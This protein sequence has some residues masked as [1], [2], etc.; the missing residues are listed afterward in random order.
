MKLLSL[1]YTEAGSVEPE[2]KTSPTSIEVTWVELPVSS[3]GIITLYEIQYGPT[4]AL[5]NITI[6]IRDGPPFRLTNLSP[7]M[8]FTFYVTPFTLL[9]RGDTSEIT[10]DTVPRK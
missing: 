8:S 4:N 9:D 2:V 7:E 1:M 3:N 5:S 10:A 6:I